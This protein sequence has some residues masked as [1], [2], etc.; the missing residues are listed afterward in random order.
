VLK[1]ERVN[2]MLFDLGASSP[3]LDDPARGFSFRLDAPL[4]MRMDPTAGPTAAQ[5][6][7]TA[8]EQQI[9]AGHPRLWRRTVC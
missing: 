1:G 8:E 3:Q 4:D 6:L 7:A 2:G 5:W 9:R